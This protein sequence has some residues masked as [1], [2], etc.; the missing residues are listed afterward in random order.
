MEH[1][2]NLNIERAV[3]SSIIFDPQTYEEIASKLSSHDFYLPFHQYIFDA[4]ESLHKEEKPLDDEFLQTKLTSMGK[5]DETAMLELLSANPISNTL[6]YIGE[7]KA[8]SNKRALATLATEI[9][10]VTIEDDLPVEEVMNLVEKKLYEITQNSTSNDFRES[11]E[12]TLAMMA[13]IERLKALG[14][15][16]L[17]GVDTGFRNLNDKTSGFGKGDLVIIAARPAMGKCFGK[18]TKILMYSGELKKVEDIVVGDLLMGDDSSPRRVLSLARGREEMY[19]VHQNKGIDYRV[20]KSHI[21]SLKRS[22]NGGK[23]THGDIL[24][25]SVDAYLKRSEKFKTNYKG[26]KVGVEFAQQEVEIDPY[27]LG[28]WLGDGI[29]S[30]TGITTKDD[31]II[32][33]LNDYANQLDKKVR[34]ALQEA[35]CPIYHISNKEGTRNSLQGKLRLLGVL[36]NKH[37]PQHYLINS[38]ENRLALLAGLIDSDGYYDDKYHVIEITQ[39]NQDLAKQIKFLADS[40]GFRCSFRAKK[41]GIKSIGYECEVY[42][43]RMVGDL[44]T[45]PTKIARKQARPSQSNR[46]HQHTGIKVEYDKIDDY[47][48]FE[49]DGNRLF[50]LE[51]MTVTHNTS[52]VLNMTLKAIERNEGVA[53]FSLEM[54]AEQ[55]MLRLLSAKTSIPLQALRVGDLR[56]EQWS[57]LSSAT[58][59]LSSKKL[60]V[61]DGGYATI[62]HVRSK[63]RKLKTQHPEITVAVIDYLQ[64]MSG[65]AKEGRQQVVSEISRGLKQLARELQIPILALSQLNRG[66]ESRDNKRPMLSDLRE[67]GCLAGDS[68]ITDALSGKRYKIE[69]L[70]NSKSLLPMQTKAMDSN[71]QLNTFTITH[72]FCSGKKPLYRLTTKSGKTIEATANHKFYRLDGWIPLENLSVGD[73][74]ATPQIMKIDKA[75]NTLSDNELILLAHLLG[76]GCILEKQPYHYTNEDM[77]NI[78]IVKKVA[79]ELFDID[80]RLVEQKNWWHLYLTSPYPLTHHQKHP[81][82]LWY[83]QLKLQRVRSYKKVIPEALF[84]SS[85]RGIKLFLKHLWATDGSITLRKQK[86]RTDKVTVYYSSTSDILAHQVQS[87]LLRVGIIS[88]VRMVK[89]IKKEKEYRPS[90]HVIVQGKNDLVKFLKEIGSFGKRGE[91]SEVYLEILEQS[92]ANPNNGCIDKSV[93]QTYI[94]KAKDKKNISWRLFAE[95]LEMSYCG[96]TLFKSGVS[97]ERMQKIA[98][99]LEDKEIEKLAYTTLYWDEIVSIKKQEKALTYD[100]TVDEVHNFVANDIIVHNSIEQDADI[101]MFVYRDDVYREAMEKEKE[102]KAKAEGK[103]YTSEFHK[104]PEEEAEIIIGKQRNGPTGTVKLV[105]QKQFTRFVDAVPQSGFEIEYEDADIP[106]QE[107]NINIDMPNI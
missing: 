72:A 77:Q 92:K 95:K 10:K 26:Y 51:D 94:K 87:L 23:H 70:A 18:G 66:V 100:L 29:S 14:N 62:H 80:A 86:N 54:P 15:S 53:F 30:T 9:K 3:L 45:I 33:Y 4:M 50:L 58:Q 101:V 49:I 74:I 103:E 99:F 91:N 59:E 61:D 48:G 13:E 107:A 84:E 28:L 105:F 88:K 34:H 42:R 46:N 6:A 55:L 75:Q 67:S 12:I 21:L 64:L 98:G 36:N 73:K 76:D 19:W 65:E 35:K 24:N 44:D 52:V 40:L 2:Y 78:E 27:F 1:L 106:M 39:K 83:E 5:F 89:Q 56:D 16:K 90:Y 8:K 97:Q 102:M 82:T 7:I 37:I 25:I 41:A 57:Q 31:E 20:N 96:T 79:K 17:I 43:V 93:W 22:R 104:K 71:L 69:E 11:D 81:I 68:I 38:K 47:Y 85:S 60:F 32:D 63:L